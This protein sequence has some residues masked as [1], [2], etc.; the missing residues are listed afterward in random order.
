M[1]L[2]ETLPGPK[3]GSFAPPKTAPQAPTGIVPGASAFLRRHGILVGGLACVAVLAG[4]YI[5]YNWNNDTSGTPVTVAVTQGD[6]ENLVTAIG[7]LQPL[8]TVDVGAQ[9]SGQLKKLYVKIGDTTKQGDLVAQIDSTVAA[10]KV[11]ADGAQLQ[12]FQ[13]LL[14]DKQ[15]SQLLTSA[16][17]DRQ[18]RLK[19]ENATSQD[20]YDSAQAAMRSAQA[21]VKALQAQIT[22]A[23]S[24]L[25]ADRA[26]LGY[27]NIYAPM[28][29]TVTAIPAKEGQTLNANQ[30]APTLLTISD[31]ATMTVY[32]QV[33]E[34]DVPKLHLGMDAYF[35]TLGN[36]NRRYPGTLRQILPTPTVVNN[37]VLYTALFDVKNPDGMLLPQM[38]AQVFFVLA[39]A[40]NVVVMP[41][42]ALKY[43]DSGAR[44]GGPQPGKPNSTAK[45]PPRPATVTVVQPSGATETRNV[46]VGVTNRVDA[47]IVSGLVPGE[48]VIAGTQSA[49][50]AKTARPATSAAAPAAGAGNFGRG[51]P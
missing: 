20:L 24:T 9:V 29:G 33:S 26:T 13:A 8:N 46:T 36:S 38:T 7:S 11:D 31:L 35:T 32:T 27:A 51:S 39:S 42:G 1:S 47:E 21:Q 25:K 18:T 34:A 17:A 6:I 30:Q 2:P 4:A 3:I 44:A 12:N 10:A 22:Q 48:K 41:V 19:N 28:T 15:S 14:S 37:V 49:T 40:H 16:Q 43:A 5:A 23:Q 45:A 50:A